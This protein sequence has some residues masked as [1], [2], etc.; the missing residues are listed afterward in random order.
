MPSVKT[1][2]SSKA[3]VTATPLTVDTITQDDLKEYIPVFNEFVE[4]SKQLNAL[5]KTYEAMTLKFLVASTGIKNENKIKAMT[6]DAINDLIVKRLKNG[7]LDFEEGEFDYTI[8]PSEEN[9]RQTVAWKDEVLQLKGEDYVKEL[10]AKT[11][12]T[13]SY[14]VLPII[15]N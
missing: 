2:T 15:E 14:K 4:L 1:Q 12:K 9:G 11:P 5:K 3:V 7:A 6:P 10:Q 13:F 8:A